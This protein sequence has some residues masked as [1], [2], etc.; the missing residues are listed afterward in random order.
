MALCSSTICTVIFNFS[1]WENFQSIECDWLKLNMAP[2]F[3][4]LHNL[5]IISEHIVF[6]ASCYEFIINI[7][8]EFDAFIFV[9]LL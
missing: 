7:P 1:N 6:N 3:G 9:S 5:L 4:N 2:L 8:S